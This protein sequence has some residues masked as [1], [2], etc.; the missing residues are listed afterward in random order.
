MK[1]NLNFKQNIFQLN[2]IFAIIIIILVI[3]NINLQI[4]NT[5]LN[6]EI[7]NWAGMN[8]IYF[9]GTNKEITFEITNIEV[10]FPKIGAGL[11]NGDW[12]IIQEII[13]SSLDQDIKKNLW[14][15]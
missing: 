10:H 2:I 8:Y 13:D 3:V 11:A 4:K 15:L 12:N 14:A 7:L 6:N 9:S 5:D 1:L